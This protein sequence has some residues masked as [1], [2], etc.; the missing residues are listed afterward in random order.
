MT[1]VTT[2]SGQPPRSV[3]PHDR[4]S[5]PDPYDVDRDPRQP[6]D[7]TAWYGVG[8]GSGGGPAGGARLAPQRTDG[9]RQRVD[10]LAELVGLSRTR[11]DGDVLAHAGTL[12]ERVAERR[13]LSLDH[14]VVALAGATGSGKSSLF[15]ALTGTELSKVGVR[16]PTTSSP[17]ACAWDAH[18][19]TALMDRLAIPPHARF[20]RHT[21]TARRG[22]AE[23]AAGRSAPANHPRPLRTAA[24]HTPDTQRDLRPE[25]GAAVELDGL[26]LIDLP[27]HDSAARG[28]REQVDRLLDLV[29]VVVWVLDPEK[30]ADAVLHERYLRPLA[31]HADVMLVVLNQVD[32]L[33]TEAAEQVLD[34]LRRLLDEDGLAVGEHG[35]AGAAVLA[36]SALTG[37]GLDELTDVIAQ[38]VAERSA[39]GRR[40]AAD[41][42][43]ETERLRPTYIGT[44]TAGLTD[45]AREEFVARLADAIG[46]AAA[47]QTA[48]RAWSAEAARACGTWRSRLAPHGRRRVRL[49]RRRAVPP[50]STTARRATAPAA[51]RPVV[52][53]AVRTVAD[54][55]AEGLPTPWARA[56]REAARRGARGLPEALD[57]AAAKAEATEMERPRWWSVARAAQWLLAVLTVAGLAGV[58]VV[59]GGWVGLP[60][61]LPAVLAGVGVLGGPVLAWACRA[62]SRGPAR[63]YGQST[64]RRL[65]DAAA[66]CGRARVL[67]PI[68]AE[69]LRYREVREQ[70]GVAAGR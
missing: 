23:T 50:P 65:R 60:V 49:L 47:G 40:L 48:Q 2:T 42:D 41:L 5:H 22:T 70:Y 26:I 52:D 58:G 34:D 18:G 9:L 24:Q 4:H 27:D 7:H 10:A 55:A 56:V 64:E 66:D 14:T 31:K 44:G 30:Y 16:R 21:R 36:V 20:V 33:P 29:D 59:V 51:A 28:H 43:R 38:V 63:R 6:G 54:A 13:R 15:N 1:A 37:E 35:E 11:V 25:P 67:E 69:L 46:A 57:V 53:E 19:A 17:V 32:R 61:W 12:V 39:A 62:G 45:A 8:P 3:G 68:A